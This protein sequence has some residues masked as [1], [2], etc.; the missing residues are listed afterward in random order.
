MTYCLYKYPQRKARSRHLK[1]H[2]AK[3]LKLTWPRAVQI[4]DLYRPEN[5]PEFNSYKL[6]SITSDMEQLFLKI[7]ALLPKEYNP[8]N[9]MHLIMKFIY[10]KLDTL[11]TD[12]TLIEIPYKIRCIFYLLA[13]FYF[14]NRDFAKAIK[15]YTMDLTIATSRFDSWAGMALSKA[16]RIETKLNALEPIV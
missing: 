13:D 2:E 6:E 14:K 11:P 16:S 10:G 7:I 3:Q 8:C 12:N 9:S 4:F 5:L 15:Y 1:E